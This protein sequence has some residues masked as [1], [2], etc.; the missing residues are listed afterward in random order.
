MF[1]DYQIDFLGTRVIIVIILIVSRRYYYYYYYFVIIVNVWRRSRA[2][3]S[4]IASCI[5]EDL[6]IDV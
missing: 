3:Y 6:T 4:V 1:W 5:R 2:I